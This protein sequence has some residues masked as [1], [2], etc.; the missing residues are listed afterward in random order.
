MHPM[1]ERTKLTLYVNK[2][3]LIVNDLVPQCAFTTVCHGGLGSNS[4]TTGS[5]EQAKGNQQEKEECPDT[6]QLYVMGGG[7]N[8]HQYQWKKTDP[9]NLSALPL[10]GL[11]VIEFGNLVSVSWLEKGDT[12]NSDGGDSNVRGGVN[13]QEKPVQQIRVFYQNENHELAYLR[14]GGKGKEKATEAGMEV[15]TLMFGQTG[16]KANLKGR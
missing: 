8:L 13:D 9:Q 7:K 3:T 5:W 2:G 15:V 10:S 16:G 11:G 14:I 4:V 1:G 6:F 12:D